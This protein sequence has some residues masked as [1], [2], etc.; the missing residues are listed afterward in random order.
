MLIAVYWDQKG[1]SISTPRQRACILHLHLLLAIACGAYRS[2]VTCERGKKKFTRSNF[3][4]LFSYKGWSIRNNII[5]RKLAPCD[6]FPLY[7]MSKRTREKHSLSALQ[8]ARSWLRVAITDLQISPVFPRN[9]SQ[10]DINVRVSEGSSPR[11]LSNG[12][13]NTIVGKIVTKPR[14]PK[15]SA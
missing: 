9:F 13:C 8:S 4:T 3:R 11:A 10:W 14:P 5:I 1:H 12:A 2:K 6:N 15:L 7:G